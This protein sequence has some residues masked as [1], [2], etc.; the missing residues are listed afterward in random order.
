MEFL[1]VQN[2]CKTYGKGD[3][4]VTALDHVSLT[5]A[6]GEFTAIIGSSGSGKTT[7]LR[8]LNFLEQ[9]DRGRITVGGEVLF[10][11]DDPATQRESASTLGWCSSRS[12]SFPSTPRWKT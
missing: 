11:A 8:C 10:D 12:T 4:Q 1:E 5:I 2:L 9:P 3:K 6:K 7:L